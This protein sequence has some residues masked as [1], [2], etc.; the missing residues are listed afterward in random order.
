MKMTMKMKDALKNLDRIDASSIPD[1]KIAHRVAALQQKRKQG[2]FTLLE[3]L[4]VVAI[5]AAI[6]G[7]A[8]VAFQ[9]TDARASAAAHVQ[10]MNELDN[11]TR[12]YQKINRAYPDSWDSIMEAPGQA[13]GTT[14][15][16]QLAEAA[17]EDLAVMTLSEVTHGDDATTGAGVAGSVMLERLNDAGITTLRVAYDTTTNA[18]NNPDGDGDCDDYTTLIQ[19]K[20][21]AVVA[22]NIYLSAA[23]NGCGDD[24]TLIEASNIMVWVGGSERVS[25]EQIASGAT[26]FIDV[27]ADGVVTAAAEAL[28]TNVGAPVYMAVGYGPSGTLFDQTKEAGLSTVP[29]YRHVGPTEYN[30]FTALFKIAEVGATVGTLIPHS[31]G[32]V[33]MSGVVDGAGDTKEEE[34]GEWDGTRSTI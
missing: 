14:G 24:H 26:D 20:G 32:A 2:G 12:T 9:D 8:V 19:S 3:L 5:M 28:A 18:A 22:G 30:R 21:N 16:V 34:L 6:A 4:V 23:A 31:D 15:V 33:F 13:I 29:V 10:M 27:G 7:S 17:H 11:Y 1:K 25:G